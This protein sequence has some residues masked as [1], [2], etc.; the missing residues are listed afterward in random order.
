[1]KK[2]SF[3]LVL[4]AAIMSLLLVS[5]KTQPTT[6]NPPEVVNV[7]VSII[8]PTTQIDTETPEITP[9]P[10]SIDTDTATPTPEADTCVGIPNNNNEEY[11]EQILL[12][13]QSFLGDVE[14][15]VNN[16]WVKVHDNGIGEY[17]VVR[18]IGTTNVMVRGRWGAGCVSTID[19]KIIVNGEFHNHNGDIIQVR[20]VTVNGNTYTETW[21]TTPIP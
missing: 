17:T 14:I 16:V 15:L 3:I 10:G 6:A 20:D 9:T 8:I 5:C 11:V 21:F 18:N 19:Q 4:V 7:N 2:R 13:G 12:P 1:M